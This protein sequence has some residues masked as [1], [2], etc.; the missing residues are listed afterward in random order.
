MDLLRVERILRIGS[1]FLGFSALNKTLLSLLPRFTQN[2]SMVALLKSLPGI[3]GI[4]H[5]IQFVAIKRGC[6]LLLSSLL[7]RFVHTELGLGNSFLQNVRRHAQVFAVSVL[8]LG[9]P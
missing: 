4:L 9:V 5:L 6:E 2:R 7:D 8:L 3:E 1:L